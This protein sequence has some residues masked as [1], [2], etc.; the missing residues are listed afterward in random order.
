[1]RSPRLCEAQRVANNA[2]MAGLDPTIHGHKHSL[3]WNRG[4][5]G[6]ARP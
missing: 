5:P 6:Q 1:M 3:A 2:V 4:C